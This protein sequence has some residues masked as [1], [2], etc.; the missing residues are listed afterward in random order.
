VTPFAAYKAEIQQC[1]GVVLASQSTLSYPPIRIP[2][3]EIEGKHVH[4]DV[5][6]VCGKKRRLVLFGGCRHGR[7]GGDGKDRNSLS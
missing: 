5:Y 7:V 3:T 6:N 1:F 2:D 4:N